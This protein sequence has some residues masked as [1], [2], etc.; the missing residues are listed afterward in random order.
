MENLDNNKPDKNNVAIKELTSEIDCI[1]CASKIMK[2]A[3]VCVSCGRDQRW[4]LNHLKFDH[5]GLI[6][7]LLMVLLGYLQF[8]EA[9]KD[10]LEASEAL[11]RARSAEE[12]SQE[13]SKAISEIKV[14]AKILA[15]TNLSLVSRTGRWDSGYSDKEKEEIK[16]STLNILQRLKLPE[17]DITATINDSGW[18]KYEEFD[19][20]DSICSYN[21]LHKYLNSEQIK[22]LN[23]LWHDGTLP[24]SPK[25]IR[26]FLSSA[27]A[28]SSEVNEL[29]KDYDY[30][31]KNHIHRRPEIWKKRQEWGDIIRKAYEKT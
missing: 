28:L 26:S 27:G 19:Y 2:H 23:N 17:A 29:I 15:K 14:M 5:I 4:L 1:Y 16:E 3:K 7:A 9:R 25:T 22:E 30:Y 31:I 12:I 8:K 21:I 10:R 18:H 13:A 24:P 11:Q 6:I 20:A